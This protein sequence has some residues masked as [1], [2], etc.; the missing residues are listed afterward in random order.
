M[1]ALPGR[2]DKGQLDWREYV[3]NSEVQESKGFNPAF[4]IEHGPQTNNDHLQI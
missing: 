1:A 2:I 3:R 4:E